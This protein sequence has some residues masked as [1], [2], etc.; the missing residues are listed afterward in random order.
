MCQSHS[1]GD[2]NNAV[3]CTLRAGGG[4]SRRGPALDEGGSRGRG[5]ALRRGAGCW[6]GIS[7]AACARRWRRLAGAGVRDAAQ[8]MGGHE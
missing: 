2:D 3:L 7:C 5:D 6:A 8:G 4:R 1:Q